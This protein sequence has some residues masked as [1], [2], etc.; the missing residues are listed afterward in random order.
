MPHGGCWY[1]QVAPSQVI[2]I[3]WHGIFQ[4][5]KSL[6]WNYI[7]LK[8][9]ANNVWIFDNCNYGQ[10]MNMYMLTIYII[11][12]PFGDIMLSHDLW[13]LNVG[14]DFSYA[15]KNHFSCKCYLQLFYSH[16]LKSQIGTFLLILMA[17]VFINVGWL[18]SLAT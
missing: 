4:H 7:N 2:G 10:R 14:C 13:W 1:C 5:L 15:I 16:K 11:H 8:H 18:P 3:W 9:V 12:G 6:F 17:L